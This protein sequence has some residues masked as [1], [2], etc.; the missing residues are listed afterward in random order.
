[1]AAM[2]PPPAPISIMSITGALIG[3]P[4]PFLNRCSRAASMNG[5]IS[6]R[7]P[8]IRQAFAVVPPMSNEMMSALSTRL[9]KNAVARPPPAGPLSSIR[10]GKARAASRGNQATGRLHQP[11]RAAK[12]AGRQLSFQPPE[13]TV[14]Q[15]LHIGIRAGRGEALVFPKF[16]D[17][18]RRNRNGNFRQHGA[19]GFGCRTLVGGVAVA[20]QETNGNRL[21]AI[22][23]K[24]GGGAAHVTEVDR[25][26]HVAVAIHALA[27]F[28]PAV[29]RHQRF[30]ELQGQIIDVVALLRA[31]FENVAKSGCGQQT[32][33]RAFALDQGIRHER[34]CREQ[35]QRCRRETGRRP[36]PIR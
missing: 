14:G 29:A 28:Q 8:S 6:A 24:L 11:Q 34:G 20:V 16:R 36:A 31:H 7:P 22:S 2:E 1:M 26:H 4:E 18:G 15:R 33:F 12:S 9:P 13:I 25:L 3:M 10:M 21:D 30:G 23:G 19:D 32:K 35:C 17:H 27:H 5:A